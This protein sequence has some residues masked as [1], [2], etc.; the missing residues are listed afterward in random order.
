MHDIPPLDLFKAF[1]P[2]PR[3]SFHMHYGEDND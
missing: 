1:L 2:I 3:F